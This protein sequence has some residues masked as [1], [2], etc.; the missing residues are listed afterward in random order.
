[1]TRETYKKAH[2]LVHDLTILKDI[3]FE[4]DKKHCVGFCTPGNEIID[5]FWASELQDDFQEFIIR[6]IEKANKMLEEL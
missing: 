5:S 2:R 4:H 3:K 1:M 6:E